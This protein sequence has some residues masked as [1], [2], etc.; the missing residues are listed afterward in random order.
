M[1]GAARAAVLLAAITAC[2]SAS[3]PASAVEID[4][5]VGY[6]VRRLR[7]R[8]GEPLTATFERVRDEARADAK[9]VAVLFSA[10][11]CTPCQALD[12]EL[13][14][15]HPAS[16]IGHV[17]IFELK[18]EEWEQATR[19]DEFNALRRRWHDTVDSYPILVLLDERDQKRE[20]M[21]EAIVRLEGA[22]LEPTLSM[23]LASTRDRGG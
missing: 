10:D 14:N 6:D 11:W 19:M 2:G 16:A 8:N 21:Q 7:P 9:Q 22:G 1:R 13:G 15:V 18:E 5:T 17:R 12:A 20:E 23:W 4:P 3:E